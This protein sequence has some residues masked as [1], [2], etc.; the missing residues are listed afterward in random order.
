MTFRFAAAARSIDDR[1]P[2][3]S[4]IRFWGIPFLPYMMKG[5]RALFAR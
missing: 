3:G 2:P 1:W 5:N 4:L